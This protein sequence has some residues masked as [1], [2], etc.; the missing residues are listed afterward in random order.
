[1]KTCLITGSSKGLGASLALVFA[2]N[3]YN[4]ILHGRDEESLEIIKKA[5]LESNVECEI[6]TG[7]ITSNLIHNTIDKIYE[8]AAERDIDILIN[9]AGIYSKKSFQDMDIREAEDI[10]DVNLIAPI[11][12]INKIYPIFQDK[13][14]GLIIN[15]NSLAGKSPN[16]LE[17]VYCSSKYGLKGFMES[18]QIEANRNNIRLINVYLG[19]MQ[20]AITKRRKDYKN[21]IQTEEV[22]DVIFRISKNYKSLRITEIDLVRRIY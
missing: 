5:I 19:A 11:Q 2:K 12:L 10:I 16:E 1:M 21:L 22:A 3:G 20:T 13:K 6:V 9:N 18:F 4:I 14:S 17:A 7:D 15:I 8:A